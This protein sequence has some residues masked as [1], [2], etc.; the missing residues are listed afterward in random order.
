M[1]NVLIGIA[2][3]I[4]IGY[5]LRKMED[6]GKFKCIHDDMRELADRTKKKFKDV[7]DK[8]DNQAEYIAD[9]VE[10]VT[11]KTKKN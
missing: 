11:E 4:A 6:D 8:G 10:H 3:G 7:V 5:V 9:R 1:K 2:A